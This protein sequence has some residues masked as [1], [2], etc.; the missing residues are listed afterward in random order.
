MIADVSSGELAAQAAPVPSSQR[1][2][3]L[4]AVNASHQEDTQHQLQAAQARAHA[5][6]SRAA[7]KLRVAIQ[8]GNSERSARLLEELADLKGADHPFVRKL[9]AYMHIHS[10]DLDAA[11]DILM[12]ILKVQPDDYEAGL[13]MAVVDIRANRLDAARQR[14]IRLQEQYPERAAIARHLRQLHPN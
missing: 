7:G 10:G 11:R 8:S 13:N 1:R 12:S 4:V 5:A 2:L 14:L 6:V 3:P 9:T